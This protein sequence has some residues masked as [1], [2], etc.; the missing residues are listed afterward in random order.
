[1]AGGERENKERFRPIQ[2]F[3]GIHAAEG[4]PSAFFVVAF[5]VL[6][7]FRLLHAPGPKDR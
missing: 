5:L 1:M 7:Q 2:V 6:V 4:K 3:S